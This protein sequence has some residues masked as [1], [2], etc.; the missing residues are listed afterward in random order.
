VKDPAKLEVTNRR[1][2]QSKNT[3][4]ISRVNNS[5]FLALPCLAN[6][7]FNRPVVG[8]GKTKLIRQKSQEIYYYFR[9]T[10]ELAKHINICCC[11][12]AMSN[13]GSH[14]V[15][16]KVCAAQFRFSL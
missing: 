14:A 2:N 11:S 15:Q 8:S 4:K 7:I 16:T 5:L 10:T 9:I 12:S 3:R 13:P 6:F 1:Q